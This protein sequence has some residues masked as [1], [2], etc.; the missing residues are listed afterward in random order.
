MKMLLYLNVSMSW[1]TQHKYEIKNKQIKP[2]TNA[3]FAHPGFVNLTYEVE[4]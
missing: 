4:K 3:K 2:K 1:M